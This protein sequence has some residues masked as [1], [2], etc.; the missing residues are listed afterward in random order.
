MVKFRI[1]HSI[2]YMYRH[3]VKIHR[4]Y[5]FKS[6]DRRGAQIFRKAFFGLLQTAKI[7]FLSFFNSKFQ[8]KAVLRIHIEKMRMRIQEKISMRMWIHA[9]TELWR[10]K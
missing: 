5:F 1:Q 2:L 4:V 6:Y 9:L 7:L 8:F 10:A 3:M